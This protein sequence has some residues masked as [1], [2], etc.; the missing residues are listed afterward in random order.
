MRC[1]DMDLLTSI[2]LALPENPVP[3]LQHVAGC[4]ECQAAVLD[5]QKLRGLLLDSTLPEHRLREMVV[6]ALDLEDGVSAVPDEK[7]TAGELERAHPTPGQRAAVFAC[8]TVI[9]IVVL[10]A[11]SAGGSGEVAWP[12]LVAIPLLAGT[13]VMYRARIPG[14]STL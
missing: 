11:G 9:A 10:L 3:V 2:A 6:A 4:E 8:A 7:W 14:G 13:A 12:A 5:C 1:V